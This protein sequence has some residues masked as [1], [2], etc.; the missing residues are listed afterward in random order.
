MGRFSLHENQ[1]ETIFL[2]INPQ[3]FGLIQ[4]LVRNKNKK[5]PGLKNVKNLDNQEY[6]NLLV[7]IPFY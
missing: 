7:V 6:Q 2:K 1:S 5:S 4:K 3:T